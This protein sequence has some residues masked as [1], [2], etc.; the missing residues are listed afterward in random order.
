MSRGFRASE[1]KYANPYGETKWAK[2]ESPKEERVAKVDSL[3]KKPMKELISLYSTYWDNK[4]YENEFSIV[5]EAIEKKGMEASFDAVKKLIGSGDWQEIDR[6]FPPSIRPRDL[7]TANPSD[8][9]WV[10]GDELE[11]MRF[12]SGREFKDWI[13]SSSKVK[14]DSRS[15]KNEI[16]GKEKGS[17]WVLEN[18]AY[19]VVSSDKR[20]EGSINVKTFKYIDSKG[21]ETLLWKKNSYGT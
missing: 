3:V 21:V 17:K 9:I 8:E 10:M 14:S 15:Y 11:E 1:G 5:E 12:G 20:R 13:D 18:Q 2:G 6:T 16:R 7:E 19:D 4:K